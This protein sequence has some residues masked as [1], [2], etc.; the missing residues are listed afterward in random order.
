LKK[1]FFSSFYV[2]SS[3][4]TD[5]GVHAR[6]QNFTLRIPFFLK[7]KKIFNVLQKNLSPCVLVKKVRKVNNN[8]HPLRNVVNKEYRY[9]IWTGKPDV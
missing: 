3:S 9:F 5:K 4:R 1:I 7:N 8:F 6:E 2:L